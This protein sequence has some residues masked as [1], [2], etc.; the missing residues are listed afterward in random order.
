MSGVDKSQYPVESGNPLISTIEICSESIASA[1]EL[2]AALDA[3]LL[4]LYPEDGTEQHFHLDA[5]E[6][7]DGQGAFL[8]AYVA[9][10]AVGCGAF[11][12]LD[13]TTAEIKRMYVRPAIRG[14]GTGRALLESLE[15]RARALGAKKLVLESGPRQPA[16]IGLYSAS[17][18][19]PVDAFGAYEASPL[20]TFMGKN[21]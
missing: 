4:A 16:A 20:S 12:M 21:L 5:S 18:F 11:R 13:A 19:V 7:S 8:V 15:E 2:I 9:G 17:G 14:T 3:E 6:V 1:R 10:E